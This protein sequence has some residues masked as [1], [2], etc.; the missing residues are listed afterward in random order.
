M[1]LLLMAWL[2][3]QHEVVQV[4][5][6]LRIVDVLPGQWDLVVRFQIAGDDQTALPAFLAN[7]HALFF[8]KRTAA[9][10]RIAPIK[11]ISKLIMHGARPLLVLPQCRRSEN[12]H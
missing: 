11:F 9:L 10:P 6:D 5:G 8:K 7:S 2:A 4:Q 1:M 3:Q 12:P